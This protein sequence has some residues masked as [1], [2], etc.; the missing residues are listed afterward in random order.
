MMNF[1]RISFSKAVRARSYCALVGGP[2]GQRD[3]WVAQL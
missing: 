1:A 3:P 2:Y